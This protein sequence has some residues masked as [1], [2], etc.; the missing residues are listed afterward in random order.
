MD[1]EDRL[2][3][4]ALLDMDFCEARDVD[5][6]GGLCGKR[7][8]VIGVGVGCCVEPVE[9]ASLV[10][11]HAEDE[12]AREQTCEKS[13]ARAGGPYQRQPRVR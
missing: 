3:G 13:W 9:D 11:G 7:E 6:V 2:T 12:T 8:A 10:G 5:L 4:A 1:E